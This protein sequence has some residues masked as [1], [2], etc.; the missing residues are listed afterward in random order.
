MLARIIP[1]GLPKREFTAPACTLRAT[2][3][4]LCPA[5][6][7]RNDMTR[8]LSLFWQLCLLRTGPEQVPYS[9][10]LALLVVVGWIVV[11][12]P[13]AFAQLPVD[14]TR[15][16]TFLVVNAVLVVVALALLLAVR[17]LTARLL[18]TVTA[19]F[20]TDLIFNALS[21]PAVLPFAGLPLQDPAPAHLAALVA[22]LILLGWGLVVKGYIL[23]AALAVPR[24]TGWMLALTITLLTT[25]LSG[26]LFPDL[27]PAAP[28]APAAATTTTY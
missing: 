27:L 15:A 2:P 28:T 7:S 12:L 5:T 16:V 9:P 18:Q 22:Q 3:S 13:L 4:A 11:T 14:G 8:E 24:F 20:G 26:A 17:G 25:A 6:G 10:A 21:L 19:F 23:G 1:D